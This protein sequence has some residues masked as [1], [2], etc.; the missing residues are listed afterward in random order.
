MTLTE[1][2]ASFTLDAAYAGHQEDIIGS[3][4]VGKKADFVLLDRDLFSIPVDE[5]WEVQALETWVN[6][7]KV[8]D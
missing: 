1:A 4:E 7:E 2:F 8:T 3:L 5:I 6:G